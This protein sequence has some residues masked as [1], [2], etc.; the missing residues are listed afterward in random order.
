MP[1]A[2]RAA[3]RQVRRII[4]AAVFAGGDVIDGKSLSMSGLRKVAILAAV[5]GANDDG[6]SCRR[7]DHCLHGRR[8][9]AERKLSLGL[10]E[11]QELTNENVPFIFAALFGG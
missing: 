10:Q 6:S 1:V 3:E 2:E 8:M 9:I 7:V 5:A 11:R 4:A